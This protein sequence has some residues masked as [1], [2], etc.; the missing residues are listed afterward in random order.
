MLV[1]KIVAMQIAG[2][3]RVA[4]A[5]NSLGIDTTAE[6]LA[7]A[8]RHSLHQIACGPFAALAGSM[9]PQALVSGLTDIGVEPIF[10]DIARK[11]M[12]SAGGEPNALLDAEIE[13]SVHAFIG[14]VV[15]TPM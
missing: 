14:D 5:L 10:I 1:E 3:G 4:D 12:I 2:A 6:T 9:E 7:H 11:R 8:M 15:G 13:R